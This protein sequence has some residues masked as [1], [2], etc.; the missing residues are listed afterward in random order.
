MVRE[1]EKT[2][3]RQLDAR[4][5]TGALVEEVDKVGDRLE[6]KRLTG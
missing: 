2:T 6:Y 4:L 3:S 1:G 5:S